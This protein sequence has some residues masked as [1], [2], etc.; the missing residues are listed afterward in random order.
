M[1]FISAII[2]SSI[3]FLSCS[4]SIKEFDESGNLYQEYFIDKDSL[5]HGEYKRYD[6]KGNL[7][8]K[9]QF[10]HGLEDGTRILYYENGNIESKS[11]YIND[12]LEGKHLVYYETG[13]LQIDSDYKNSSIIGT[14]KKFYKNG[15]LL[16]EV[17]FDNDMEN[18]P[19][20]EFYENGALK[21]EGKYLNGDYEFDTI[22][23][24]NINGTLAK[25]MYCDSM[26]IC[27][28]LWKSNETTE[29]E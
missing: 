18:G 25:V 27:K 1:K 3:L 26:R 12:K 17:S 22:K 6:P 7:V 15:N 24:Y 5:R 23:H 9:S 14:L 11:N 10:T 20:K 19:F 4:N 8:E 28:T 16:E 2:F 29:N 13:E 21:W